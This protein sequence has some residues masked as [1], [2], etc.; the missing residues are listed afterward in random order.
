MPLDTICQ[1]DVATISRQA[2]L[3]SASQLMYEKHVGSL[4]VVEGYQGN[5]IPCGI[6]TDRD[7]ALAMGSGV[8]N[9]ENTMVE[10]LMMPDPVCAHRSDGIFEVAIKMKENGI[11]RV[12]VV[13]D[14]G[15]L[16][17]IISAEDIISLIAAELNQI[18]SISFQQVR[19]EKKL[20]TRTYE[21]PQ[22][23]H[24]N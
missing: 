8:Y 9:L 22:E 7:I 17:G 24:F 19:R 23:I 15:A 16:C 5:Q 18:A 11:K 2:T 13:N 14:M 20:K 12:P 3:K 10:N 6:I 21:M 4:I 1:K